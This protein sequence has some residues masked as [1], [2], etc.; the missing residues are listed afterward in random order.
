RFWANNI[1]G[2]LAAA[3]V[4]AIVSSLFGLLFSYHFSLPS[5]PAIIL[6]AGVVYV[7]SLVVGP[8]SGL[9]AKNMHRPTFET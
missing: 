3:V 1:G 4:T 7:V 5:G 8:V 6:V 2:L 9:I